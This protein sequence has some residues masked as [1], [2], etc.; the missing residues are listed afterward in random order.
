MLGYTDLGE[1]L[2]MVQQ[3]YKSFTEAGKIKGA[4][5]KQLTA[6]FKQASDLLD[7]EH[8]VQAVK[9]LTD[10]LT[11]LDKSTPGAIDIDAKTQVNADV[12]ALIEAFEKQVSGANPGKGN[13]K[14]REDVPQVPIFEL[15]DLSNDFVEPGSD[16]TVSV[17]VE[18]I[19]L[20][21]YGHDGTMVG[22]ATLAAGKVGNALKLDGGWVT[23]PA[24]ELLE[25]GD[26]FTIGAWVNLE[27]A[28][29]DQKI[30][31]KPIGS[32][33]V[34]AVQGGL[35]PEMWADNG[36]RYT[37]QQGEI[38]SKQW[39]HIAITWE[40]NGRLIGYING[41]VVANIAAGSNPIKATNHPL[42][43]GGAPWWP[44]GLQTR[45]LVDEVKIY[46]QALSEQEI[47]QLFT[48]NSIE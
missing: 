41:K 36:A 47:N 42:I 3:T 21:A 13:W 6:K 19:G 27:D 39:T 44:N 5:E 14:Y 23:V 48:D 11:V 37:F 9:M 22:N 46:K 25:G 4:L 32:G 2:E 45:G 15:N 26:S 30:I 8:L 10:V 34:L 28:G 7:K 29:K 40:K 16:A 17:D 20:L 18:N 43:I 1:K 12:H 33:Y 38:V 24:N 35:Y 31:G